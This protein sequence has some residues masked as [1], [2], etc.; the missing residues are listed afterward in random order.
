MMK[1]QIYTIMYCTHHSKALSTQLDP[2]GS[3]HEQAEPF[4]LCSSPEIQSES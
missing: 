2:K 1:A 3:W 4:Y